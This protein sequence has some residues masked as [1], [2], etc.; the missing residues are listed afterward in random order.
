M[1]LYHCWHWIALQLNMLWDS[2]WIFLWCQS[3]SQT[4]SV[5]I[6]MVLLF[7]WLIFWDKKRQVFSVMHVWFRLITWVAV[8]DIELNCWTLKL[9]THSNSFLKMDWYYSLITDFCNYEK[10]SGQCRLPS[11]QLNLS[12]LCVVVISLLSPDFCLGL[13]WMNYF[14]AGYSGCRKVI[15]GRRIT[16]W[17]QITTCSIL[18]SIGWSL[19]KKN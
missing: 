18:L 14:L 1:L 6:S 2:D 7:L 3:T 12:L 15:F 13:E 4:R 16:F 5:R 11:L 9:T 10:W 19:R 8:I 17:P